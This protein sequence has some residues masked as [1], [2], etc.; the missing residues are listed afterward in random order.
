MN[1]RSEWNADEL[2]K[3]ISEIEQ[4]LPHLENYCAEVCTELSGIEVSPAMFRR[5]GGMWLMHLAHQVT[6]LGG[7]NHQY[8]SREQFIVPWDSWSHSETFVRS[9]EYRSQIAWIGQQQHSATLDSASVSVVRVDAPRPSRLRTGIESVVQL[10][11][12]RNVGVVVAQPYLK[13][14][15][16]KKLF[17]VIRSRQQI[18][19]DDFFSEQLDMP[20]P[21]SRTRSAISRRAIGEGLDG[22]LRHSIPLLIP[23]AMAE[24]LRTTIDALMPRYQRPSLLFSANGSQLNLKYQTISALWGEEGTRILS[25]QHGGHQGLDVIHA[26]EE[27]EV[28][29][30]HIHYSFGWSD[31]RANVRSLATAMPSRSTSRVAQR[32]LLMTLADTDVVYR[33]QPFCLPSHVQKCASETRRFLSGLQWPTTPIIRGSRRDLEALQLD[34]HFES[35]GFEQPGSISA[36]ASSLV[37]HNYLGVTWLETLAMN[38]P[39]VCFIPPGIHSFRASAQPFA[40]RLQQVGILHYSGLDAARFVNGFRGDPS[41]WWNSAEV[42]EAREAFVARYANFSDNWLE[43]WQTE[44][45]SL[46]AE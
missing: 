21:D 30:S 24:G 17:A 4:I 43:A 39:T 31:H 2:F 27:Y 42:Q 41:S 5:L 9:Q 44:F 12:P 37:V 1:P 45:E 23:V 8:Q 29:A 40:D 25:Q 28:R 34:S 35:E 38:V 46:L 10:L 26:G 14:P 32:L 36:S 11:G 18:H 20:S 7:E 15:A 16:A 33:I 6:A 19:W 13:I 3:T 22:T